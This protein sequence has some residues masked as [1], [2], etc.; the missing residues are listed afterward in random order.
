MCLRVLVSNRMRARAERYGT[1]IILLTIIGL[2]TLS[3]TNN[4]GE[5]LK[6]LFN[7]L[8]SK[9]KSWHTTTRLFDVDFLHQ[10]WAKTFPLVKHDH[11]SENISLT[12]FQQC[13]TSKLFS[14]SES[15]FC[16]PYVLCLFVFSSSLFHHIC[17]L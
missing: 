7:R 10:V 14:A 6:L 1:H 8:P 17:N 4:R 16:V 13:N 9:K 12:D 2:K 11:F 15:T 5:Y 3:E